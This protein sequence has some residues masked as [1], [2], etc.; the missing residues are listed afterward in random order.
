LLRLL[1]HCFW[2]DQEGTK[3]TYNNGIVSVRV[4]FQIWYWN[5]LNYL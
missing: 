5:F 2:I 1:G 3:L 4:A